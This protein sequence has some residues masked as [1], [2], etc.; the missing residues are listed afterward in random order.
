MIRHILKMLWNRRS[1]NALIALEIF[2]AFLVLFG[3][4]AMAIY[5]YDHYRRPMGFSSESVWSVDISTGEE[6]ISSLAETGERIATLLREAR[7]FPWVE[8]A[9]GVSWAPYR[10]STWRTQWALDDRM[11]DRV[12][13]M[14]A[15]D[16][17]ERVLELEITRG[18][19]FGPEDDALHRRP[20]VVNEMLARELAGDQDPLGLVPT[21]EDDEGT[22]IE[23][24]IVG[25]I[26]DFRYKGELE[27]PGKFAFIRSSVSE[28]NERDFLEALLLRVHPG[29]AATMEEPLAERLQA[30][31][32]DWSFKLTD[33]VVAR[34]LY[35]RERRAPLVVAALL[36][37]FLMLMVALGLVGVLWQNVTQRTRELGLR[38]AKGATR[39]R[40]HQQV[41]GELMVLAA[42]AMI[43]GTAV[44]AQLPITGWLP[45]V[46]AGIYLTALLLASA[47]LA[48]LTVLSGLYPSWMAT[49]IHPAEALHYE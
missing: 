20:I 24:Q 23:Y 16:E 21:D 6:E 34:Q 36:A 17:L 47:L 22:A 38:R 43:A 44:V 41:L 9:A 4:T 12:R 14:N 13:L 39:R 10:Q 19:W 46:G 1:S 45:N 28:L 48:L 40:I 30:T 42:A 15:T 3:V 35:L 2:F 49:R 31:A 8:E 33:L 18:R 37:G 32:P 26:R 27:I 29:T 11:V 5:Y 7:S 25:V